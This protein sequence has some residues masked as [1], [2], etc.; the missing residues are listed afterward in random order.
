M[1]KDN[2]HTSNSRQDIRDRRERM[3]FLMAKGMSQK[4]I[5][6]ALDVTR[7]TVHRDIKAINKDMD[8]EYNNM[9]RESIPTMFDNCLRSLNELLKETW[10]FYIREDKT[11]THWHRLAALRLINDVTDKKFN[12]ISNG[13]ALMEINK[14]KTKLEELKHG[15][16]LTP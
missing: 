15:I 5:S 13:P 6:Q 16:Q 1:S 4:D 9:I 11:I 2:P 3:L 10:A 12:M 14:L 7:M 8:R